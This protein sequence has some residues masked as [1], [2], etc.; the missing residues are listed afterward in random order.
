[1]QCL[2]LANKRNVSCLRQHSTVIVFVWSSNTKRMLT[3][4]ANSSKSLETSS[5]HG[6]RP[7]SGKRSARHPLSLRARPR[8]MCIS[9]EHTQGRSRRLW[10]SRPY[11]D[12]VET[13]PSA[14][15]RVP[16]T[17]NNPRRPQPREPLRVGGGSFLFTSFP[18][19]EDMFNFKTLRKLT[20]LSIAKT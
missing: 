2:K 9:W 6:T 18:L 14:S 4:S 20:E 1:M 12:P 16:L 11:R 19:S 3:A 8:T 13:S 7:A 17:Q 5:R 10:A 15:Y